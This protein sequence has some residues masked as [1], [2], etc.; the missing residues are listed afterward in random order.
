ME[1]INEIFKPIHNFE[2]YH[3][4]NL[5]NVKNTKKNKLLKTNKSFRYSTVGITDG[6]KR[7]TFLIHRLVATAF[8][9][10]PENKPTVNHINHDKF[11][12]R[13]E[14]LEWYTQKEQNEYNYKTET[15]KRQTTR[16]RSVVCSDKD[17][18]N[19]IIFR[20]IAE[21][22]EWLLQ[23]SFAKNIESSLSGIRNTL[24]NGR[25]CHG[26]YWKYNDL[27]T[28]DLEGEIWQELPDEFTVG[29][30]N[31]FV[32]NKGRF[33]NN[34]GKI[35]IFKNNDSYLTITIKNKNKTI[36]HQL[37]RIVSKLFVPNKDENKLFVNHID[38]NKLNNCADNLEWV[39]KSE[40]TKHAHKLGLITK[41]CR[42][43][44]QYDINNNFIAQYNSI[45]E[46][47]VILK[48][49]K[50]SIGH[51]CAKDR[52]GSKTCGGFVFKYADA[53]NIVNS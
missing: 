27:Y 3:I 47:S 35:T 46:A 20:T 9:P 8:I 28:P 41:N 51:V 37:H 31:Y 29:K 1:K 12:N 49:D 52:R 26:Y 34:M 36:V 10:N 48:L 42:K 53:D 15:H 22:S 45:K 21:A 24:K 17:R 18:E 11:D 44:N 30:P 50:S 19:H 40:N 33:K 23:N 38:G 4:S 2:N 6:H 32:S 39:T 16:A 5:G 7:Y 25:M 13:V 14:N 43:V